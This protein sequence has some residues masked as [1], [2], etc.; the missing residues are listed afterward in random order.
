[1]SALR[2]TSSPTRRRL[3]PPERHAGSANRRVLSLVRRTTR[4]RPMRCSLCRSRRPGA[5][6]GAHRATQHRYRRPPPTTGAVCARPIAAPIG[7]SAELRR[8]SSRR[9]SK[10]SCARS[11]STCSLPRSWHHR[12]SR[13]SWRRH[14]AASSSTNESPDRSKRRRVGSRPRGVAVRTVPGP[15]S[16]RPRRPGGPNQP[17]HPRSHVARHPVLS[18]V[19]KSGRGTSRR[20]APSGAAHRAAHQRRRAVADER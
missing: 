3:P 6:A 14:R 15:E 18:G 5:D 17:G 2:T 13:R 20:A 7:S 1:M 19:S 11:A 16:R 12:A 8:G 4:S 9:R 10:D